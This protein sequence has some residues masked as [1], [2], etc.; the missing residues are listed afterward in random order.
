MI[1][2]IK[3]FTDGNVV[4]TLTFE[5]GDIFSGTEEVA[6]AGMNITAD[7]DT[8]DERTEARTAFRKDLDVKVARHLAKKIA[9]QPA[10]PSDTI[11]GLQSSLSRKVKNIERFAA[12]KGGGEDEAE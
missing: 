1:Y 4:V 9:N 6:F 7:G 10:V 12:L 11:A 2:T 5:E 3:D 8:P